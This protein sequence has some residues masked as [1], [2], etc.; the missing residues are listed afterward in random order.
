MSPLPLPNPELVNVSCC[1]GKG[2]LRMWLRCWMGRIIRHLLV[3]I[4]S[5]LIGS[6]PSEKGS[7]VMEAKR[8]GL[9]AEERPGDKEC[10]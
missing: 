9:D 10:R 8:H 1:K 2:T 3:I 4:A 6:G 7:V 5:V